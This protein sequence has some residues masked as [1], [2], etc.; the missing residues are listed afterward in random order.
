MFTIKVKGEFSGAHNLR[1]YEGKCERLHGHNWKIE[2]ELSAAKLDRLGMVMDFKEVKK[3]LAG[4]LEELDHAYLNEIPYFKKHNP[5]SENM[6]RFIYEGLA[7]EIKG[8]KKVI[9]WETDSSSASYF[10]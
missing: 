8:I 3:K 4:V 5:T 2:L 6:A 1:G 7:R 9:V 10:R